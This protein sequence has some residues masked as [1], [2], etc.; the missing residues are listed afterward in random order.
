M[1]TIL[2]NK[3]ISNVLIHVK[4]AIIQEEIVRE[5]I[6]MI[7]DHFT[8]FSF[9]HIPSCKSVKRI[10]TWEMRGKIDLAISLGG[11][12]TLISLT[13]FL[14]EDLPILGINLGGRGAIN[15][16]EVDDL[17]IAIKRLEEGK[18]L[19]EERIRIKGR[20][21]EVETNSALNEIYIT[22]ANFN[23]TPTFKVETDFGLKFSN[24]MDGIIISTPTGS[25]GYN[26]SAGGPILLETMKN[27]ILTPVLSIKYIPSLVI[28]L[29]KV[30]IS[31]SDHSY[32]I[33]DGQT[34][35]EL[36][37]KE[38]VEVTQDSSIHLVRF[39][40]KP[41]KQFYKVTGIER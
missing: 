27:M 30:L 36:K 4:E 18:Y 23:V 9:Q 26:L 20:I 7:S 22:R 29:S 14:K 5:I 35:Y 3:K 2:A 25:T 33:V 21:N 37:P 11:D 13:R 32:V 10:E 24:R 38:V 34:R 6:G 41:M 16:I 15:E 31:S 19:L 1:G 28:P 8:T 17:P 40:R 39:A 12:G